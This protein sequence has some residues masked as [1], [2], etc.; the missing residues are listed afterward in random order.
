MVRPTENSALTRSL[1]V[2]L[3]LSRL[4]SLTSILQ[5]MV[6]LLQSFICVFR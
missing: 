1:T 2:S 5:M 6:M 4:L 3:I